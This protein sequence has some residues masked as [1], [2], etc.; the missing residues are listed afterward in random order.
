VGLKGG[1]GFRETEMRECQ[2]DEGIWVKALGVEGRCASRNSGKYC[3]GRIKKPN[4]GGKREERQAIV[5][6]VKAGH[7][8]K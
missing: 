8:K 1:T 4:Y 2:A 7:W 6:S 5:Q 3:K